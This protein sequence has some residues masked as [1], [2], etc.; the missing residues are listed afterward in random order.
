[1]DFVLMWYTPDQLVCKRNVNN[2]LLCKGF[3]EFE[4]TINQKQVG[5]YKTYKTSKI[6]SN[7]AQ[8][9]RTLAT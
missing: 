4:H 8:K 9:L 3:F 7:E 5:N 6:P 1:M 2:G